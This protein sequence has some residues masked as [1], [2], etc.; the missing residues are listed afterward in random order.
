MSGPLSG[1][2]VLDLTSVVLGPL[3]TQT[4]GDMGA[5][6]VKIEGP[7]GDTTRYTGPKRSRDMS[8]L[9]MG[10][11]RNKRSIVLDLKQHSAKDVL[12]R[13]IDGAD[14]FLHS[15]RPQA[16]GR[17]GF[18]HDNVL[19]RNPRMVY[20]GVH[21]FRMDGPYNGRPAYDDVIQGLSGSADLMARLVDEPRYMPT[22]MAD[23]TCGLVTVNAILA[24][25]YEREQS[26]EGQF[27]EIPMLETMVAFNMADHIFGHAFEPPEGPMGYSRV[28]TPSRRPYKT[29]D[30]YICLLAYTDPQ[31]ER[32]WAEVGVPE[33]KDDPRF[34]S[35]ASRADNIEAV[36]S[37]AGKYIATRNT[38]E[39]LEVLPRLEIPCGEIVELESL[40]D[41][42][43][44]Q[45]IEF[46]RSEDHPTEGKITIPDIAVQFGRTPGSIDRLQPKLGEH[47]IEILRE[48]G[49]SDADIEDLQAAGATI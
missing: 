32:F 1:L 3:A 46:F 26:G 16:I 34:D 47:S 49:Y 33:L 30:G 2:R 10:L 4:L 17:L 11:N 40:P 19:S 41:D 21:G 20:A 35:L 23:K 15:I 18:G 37:L 29:L 12:W 38:A 45:A 25:L 14:V 39:W 28:L 44:L 43:H 42:P 31:W 13:L 5:D 9:Y 22:I 24:A 27:V 6:I 36:Y 7:A 8:A 48:A